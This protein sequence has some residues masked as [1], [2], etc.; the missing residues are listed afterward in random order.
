MREEVFNYTINFESN[1]NPTY[2]ALYLDP[3]RDDREKGSR[4]RKVE[5]CSIY[6][7]KTRDNE[8]LTILI[9]S[10]ISEI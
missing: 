8:N 6:G 1:A 2:T 7:E 4:K 5:I 9:F 10:R 3:P